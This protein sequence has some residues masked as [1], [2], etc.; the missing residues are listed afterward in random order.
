VQLGARTRDG[1]RPEARIDGLQE[2]IPAL[3]AHGLVSNK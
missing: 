2:L 1:V 3:R